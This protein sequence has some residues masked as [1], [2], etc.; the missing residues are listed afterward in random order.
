[1]P[2]AGIHEIAAHFKV[3]RS[4]VYYWRSRP[5]FPDPRAELRTGP[6]FDLGAVADWKHKN[7]RMRATS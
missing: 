3:N 1:M 7:I 6:V 2:L 5:G 4:T